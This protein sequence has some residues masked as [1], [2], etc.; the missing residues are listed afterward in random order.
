[1]TDREVFTAALDHADPAER[2]TFL[3]RACADDPDRRRRVEVLL[4]SYEEASRFLVAPP[5]ER[6][7]AGDPNG[8]AASEETAPAAGLDVLA[9]LAP[10]D[11]PGQLGKLGHYAV[12][13]IVGRGGMGVVLKAFDPKLHRLV[14][15]KLMAP[16]LAASGAARRRFEREARAVAAVRNEH[17]V[18]IHGVEA[19][20][21]A[22]H[23]VMEFVGGVSLQDRLD[24]SGPFGVKEIL[25]IGMQAACGLA[26]AHAQGLVHRDIKP[27]NILL[28]NG[29]ERVKITDFGLARAADDATL[30]QSGVITGTPNYMSPEQAAG[31]TVDARSD[32]FSLGCVLYALCSGH[33]PFRAETPL[34]VLRRV[35][36]DLPRPVR[37]VNPDIPDW[38][39]AIVRKLLVKN[40][41]DRFQS[42]AEV[43]ELLGQHLAHLQQPHATPLPAAV[44][45]PLEGTAPAHSD[46]LPRAGCLAALV[47]VVGLG[48]L[49][50][51]RDTIFGGLFRAGYWAPAYMLM[52]SGVLLLVL[53]LCRMA[54]NPGWDRH[55]L[56]LSMIVVAG[57]T[58]AALVVGWEDLQHG[59]KL[60]RALNWHTFGLT[61]AAVIMLL[62]NLVRWGATRIGLRSGAL[63]I[64]VPT[65]PTPVPFSQTAFALGVG[66]VV[67][68]VGFV[69]SLLVRDLTMSDEIK[70]RTLAF[71]MGVWGAASLLAFGPGVFIARRWWR[72]RRPEDRRG[73]TRAIILAGLGIGATILAV[74]LTVV[75]TPVLRAELFGPAPPGDP[76]LVINWDPGFVDRVTLERAGSVVAEEV[77]PETRLVRTVEPGT[78][79]ARGYRGSRE[80]YTESFA[81]EPGQQKVLSMFT[82]AVG[83]DGAYLRVICEDRGVAVTVTGSDHTFAFNHPGRQSVVGQQLVAGETYQLAIARG[84]EVL[85]AETVR[86][87][88]GE[89]RE[90]RIPHIV[91]PQ[92]TVELKPKAGSFPP[93]VVRMQ[94]APDCSAVA[95]ER[96]AG[97]ILVF[98]TA[99][100]KERFTI[101]R[102]RSH[103]TAF[104]FTP[105]GE[106]LAYLTQAGSDHVLRVV[107]ARDGSP[108]GKDLKPG[109][110]RSFLNSHALAYSPDGK[111][112]AVSSAHNIGPDNHW[113]SRVLRWEIPA[114]GAEPRALDPLQWQEGMIQVMRFTADGSE[115]LT[116]SDTTLATGWSW[117]KGKVSRRRDSNRFATNLL[118]VGKSRAVVG[119]RRTS[120][121]KAMI[122][123]W[124]PE[125]LREPPEETLPQYPVAFASLAISP[126]DNLIAAGSKGS[127][128]LTWEQRV[129][130]RVWD[131]Q[132]RGERA[133]LLGHTDWALALAY[134]PDG[135]TLVS[136]GKDGT[137]RFWDLSGFAP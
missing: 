90:I 43:A 71:L 12:L 10:A 51:F 21:P 86:L 63:T 62:P 32:L 11:A 137:V 31:S 94:L 14:A 69:G 44:L 75:R 42:A 78:Y 92:R 49:V 35:C 132:S 60:S 126:D 65:P 81:L 118:A 13:E 15:I 100:G 48:L 130:V 67:L 88:S 55:L 9:L 58:V 133:V 70:A 123:F 128:E 101:G 28:E 84:T 74:V 87:K 117:D 105:D 37:E 57:C 114:D 18:A 93:D 17:V 77:G 99:T 26:A 89:Q 108:Y 116:V 113:E 7:A 107:D 20:G 131:K 134:T 66:Y 125:P 103:C 119:G 109:E 30:T 85:H 59:G 110:G 95:V 41:A 112:L 4:R 96:F 106:H 50:G 127:A 25:R 136:A 68:A 121:E 64:P 46:R 135:K 36:D 124:S 33:P 24:R 23:L 47:F 61:S 45:P 80:V 16:H 73:D 111:R 97:P 27:A 3:D 79:T 29:V 56:N 76:T 104:G 54:A 19:D 52:V 98:D 82:G 1:M 6:L 2:R 5:A 38:L 120:P 102:S 40:P 8:T 34:A 72:K 122:S 129:M 22:P 91:S 83:S 39:D 53:W 115:V